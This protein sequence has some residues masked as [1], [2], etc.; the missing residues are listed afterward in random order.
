[1]EAERR[2]QDHSEWERQMG[3]DRWLARVLDDEQ[4]RAFLEDHRQST[5]ALTPMPA[6]AAA[7]RVAARRAVVAR[8]TDDPETVVRSMGT[9]EGIPVAGAYPDVDHDGPGVLLP[10]IRDGPTL[11]QRLRALA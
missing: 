5:S 6:V 4:L 1:M 9:V 8:S 3:E 10:T 2:A 11:T 7:I